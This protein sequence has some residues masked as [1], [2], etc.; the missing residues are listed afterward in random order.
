LIERALNHLVA[1]RV[2]IRAFD[3]RVR[4][5]VHGFGLPKK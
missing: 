2:K 3:V 4:V 5:Y 1:V